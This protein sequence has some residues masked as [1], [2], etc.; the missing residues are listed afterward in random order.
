MSRGKWPGGEHNVLH[1]KDDDQKSQ[2]VPI[3]TLMVSRP[4]MSGTTEKSFGGWM[5]RSGTSLRRLSRSAC[6]AATWCQE[7][8]GA[9]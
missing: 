3:V 7:K 5:V 9:P 1:A 6:R 4:V 2:K 8:R